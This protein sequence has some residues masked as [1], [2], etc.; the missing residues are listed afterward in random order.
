MKY[1]FGLL[2]VPPNRYSVMSYHQNIFYKRHN[3]NTTVTTKKS[4]IPCFAFKYLSGQINGESKHYEKCSHWRQ[5][6]A[7]CQRQN[8]H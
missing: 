2:K 8:G 7:K 3:Y 5:P 4:R 6:E 1:K